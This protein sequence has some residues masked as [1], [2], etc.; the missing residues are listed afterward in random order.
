[1][2]GPILAQRV[3]LLLPDVRLLLMS[4]YLPT[5]LMDKVADG[6]ISPDTAILTKPFTAQSLLA[7]VQEV[8][9]AP[10]PVAA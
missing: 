1:M 2:H 9:D 10:A 4:G 6:L 5:D 3:R 8:L 7:K